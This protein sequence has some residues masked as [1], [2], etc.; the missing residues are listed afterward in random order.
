MLFSHPGGDSKTLMFVQISPSSNNV[1]ETL[2]SLNFA[3]R[4]RSVELGQAKKHSD[5]SSS[6]IARLRSQV[7]KLE[8]IVLRTLFLLPSSSLSL[9]LS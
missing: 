6:E 1:T 9:S 3:T 2:C 5:S 8:V 7:K 4:A